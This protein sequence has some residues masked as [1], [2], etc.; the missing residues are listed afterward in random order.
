MVAED[1]VKELKAIAEKYNMDYVIATHDCLA[2][3]PIKVCTICITRYSEWKFNHNKEQIAKAMI[4]ALHEAIEFCDAH[5]KYRITD[6]D[7][8]GFDIEQVDD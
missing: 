3:Y 7:L 1:E 4:G 8:S 6:D 2:I 5:P